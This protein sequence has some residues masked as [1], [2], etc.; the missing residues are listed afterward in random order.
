MTALP[1]AE[2]AAR[3]STLAERL[4]GP[5][6]PDEIDPE[7]VVARLDA[8]AQA[9]GKGDCDHLAQRLAHDGLSLDAVRPVL[10]S[11]YWPPDAS[12]PAWITTLGALV[13]FIASGY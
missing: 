12:L 7:Q 9:V 8:W 4:Q 2:I 6:A 13:E 3:A 10:G 1:L 11:G 5:W